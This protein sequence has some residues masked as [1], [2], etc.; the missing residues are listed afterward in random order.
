MLRGRGPRPSGFTL[1]ELLVVIAIIGVLVAL[2]LPAVQAAREAARRSSCSNNLKQLSIGLHNY[3]DVHLKFPYGVMETGTF[4]VRD[5]WAQSILPFIEQ[6]PLFDQYQA[7][8][9]QWIMDIPATIK[10]VQIKTYKCPSDGSATNALGN[11]GGSRGTPTAGFG[12]QGS[13]VGCTGDTYMLYTA[14]LRGIFYNNSQTNFATI[15]DGTS[16]TLA[17]SE[18]IIRGSTSSGGWG[19]AG[20]YWGG[21]R[22]GGY[23]FTTLEAPNSTLADQVYQ[24]KSTTFP[25][26]PCTSLTGS[27]DTTRNFARSYHPGGVQGAFA[28]GSVRFFPNTINIVT[29]RALGTVNQSEVL[30]DF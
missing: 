29:W 27:S 10:D 9:T 25:R 4:H 11:N 14:Q 17:F 20:S 3:H 18:S 24:C 8:N 19:D 7:I 12:A 21:S 2:L 23:G 28:D 13:Y 26:A 15:V 16:N 1:V 30:N 22:W 6:G 5:C